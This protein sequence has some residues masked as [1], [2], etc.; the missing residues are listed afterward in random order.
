METST[1]T[2]TDEEL[3]DRLKTTVQNILRAFGDG[4]GVLIVITSEKGMRLESF[5]MDTEELASALECAYDVVASQP[6][7]AGAPEGEIL[8]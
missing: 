2:L 6:E 3:F 1:Q 8:Q 7:I 5:H 4:D